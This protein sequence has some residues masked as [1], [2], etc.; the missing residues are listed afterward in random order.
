MQSLKPRLPAVEALAGHALALGVGGWILSGPNAPTEDVFLLY[1]LAILALQVVLRVVGGLDLG[2]VHVAWLTGSLALHP[3]GA[4]FDLYTRL[5]WWDHLSHLAAASLVA[6]G[7]YVAIRGLRSTGLF[8]TRGWIH[9]YTLVVVVLCGVSWE[10]YELLVP[11]LT[12]YGVEDTLKDFVFDV[13]GWLCVTLAFERLLRS[14][15]ADFERTL[16]R[17][18]APE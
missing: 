13:A 15:A 17:V 12:V 16:A 5:W 1:G 3:L 9:G 4:I 2:F 14:L 18:V 7:S 6:G 11:H 10:L 8:P